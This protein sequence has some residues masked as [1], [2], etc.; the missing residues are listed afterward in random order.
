[1]ETHDIDISTAKWQPIMLVADKRVDCEECHALAVFMLLKHY[2]NSVYYCEPICQ[3]CFEQK[4]EEA[5]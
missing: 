5:D 2:P 4:Q 1:M 3:A